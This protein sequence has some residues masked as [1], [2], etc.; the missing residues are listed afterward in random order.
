MSR[1]ILINVYAGFMVLPR[2]QDFTIVPASRLSVCSGC[3]HGRQPSARCQFFDPT[4]RDQ[5]I[6]CCK[7]KLPSQVFYTLIARGA[8]AHC[9]REG[10]FSSLLLPVCRVMRRNRAFCIR[11]YYAGR[12]DPCNSACLFGLHQS[13][14]NRLTGQE[15]PVSAC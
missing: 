3:C 10:C 7:S 2:S 14:H 8:K 9:G 11:N 5:L 4:I 15:R 12:G 6:A 1:I 13:R